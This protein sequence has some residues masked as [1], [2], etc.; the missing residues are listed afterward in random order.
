MRGSRSS[1]VLRSLRE[2]KAQ[3][4]GSLLLFEALEPAIQIGQQQHRSRRERLAKWLL[5]LLRCAADEEL[6]GWHNDLIIIPCSI[7]I[8][9]KT[10]TLGSSFSSCEEAAWSFDGAAAVCNAKQTANSKQR[11]CNFADA[12]SRM[13]NEA[14]AT[15]YARGAALMRAARGQLRV[16][17]PPDHQPLAQRSLSNCK[18]TFRFDL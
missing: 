9:N 4:T 3:S 8:A 18:S 2:N 14:W 1:H 10:I 12:S 6:L 13:E 16:P 15:A 17:Q 5:R 7:Q 11:Q